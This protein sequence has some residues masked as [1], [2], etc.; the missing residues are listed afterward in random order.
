MNTNFNC[1]LAN[2]DLENVR[3]GLWVAGAELTLIYLNG[4]LCILTIGTILIKK[5]T[6]LPS[7]KEE[8]EH[9]SHPPEI[10][11]DCRRAANAGSGQNLAFSVS[12]APDTRLN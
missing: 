6:T 12:E 1:Y 11:A 4:M 2:N 7:T 3:G 8:A 10:R 5:E 9:A